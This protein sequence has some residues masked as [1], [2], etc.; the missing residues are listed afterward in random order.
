MQKSLWQGE[1]MKVSKHL[2]INIGQYQSL[3][4]GVDEAA[5]FKNADAVL[6]AELQRIDIPVDKKIKAALLWNING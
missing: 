2:T 6:I 1:R 5:D 4:L 3:K